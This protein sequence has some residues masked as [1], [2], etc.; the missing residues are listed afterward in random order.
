MDTNIAD[1]AIRKIGSNTKE[2]PYIC[3]LCGGKITE[4]PKFFGCVNFRIKKCPY[5]IWKTHFDIPLSQ[6][7]LEDLLT[8]GITDDEIDGFYSKKRQEEFSARLYY[9]KKENKLRFVEE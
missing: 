9:S 5:K 8:K 4:N 7:N 2:T 1:G 6:K 3:P